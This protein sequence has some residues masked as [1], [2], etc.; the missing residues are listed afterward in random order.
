MRRAWGRLVRP[1]SQGQPDSRAVGPRTPSGGATAAP[2]VN[3]D[4]RQ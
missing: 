3:R 4:V 2:V 1:P